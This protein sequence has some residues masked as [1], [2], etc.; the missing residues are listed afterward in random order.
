[1]SPLGH[2]RL[3]KSWSLTTKMCWNAKIHTQKTPERWPKTVRVCMI[4][5][6]VRTIMKKVCARACVCVCLCVCGGSLFWTSLNESTSAGLISVPPFLLQPDSWTQVT[7]LS[8]EQT[9]HELTEA[10]L[11]HYGFIATIGSAESPRFSYLTPAA[12]LRRRVKCLAVN[13]LCD[14]TDPLSR[15]DL[16]H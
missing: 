11:S 14:P 7:L 13:W 8:P 5:R 16:L 1:M 15:W 4:N 10:Y 2:T 6:V 12:F 3:S 9:Q